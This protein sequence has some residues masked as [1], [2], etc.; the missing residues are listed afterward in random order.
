MHLKSR[1]FN[2]QK[3]K[4][5]KKRCSQK[6][7]FCAISVTGGT[8][9]QKVLSHFACVEGLSLLYVKVFKGE[10]TPSEIQLQTS[11]GCIS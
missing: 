2:S 9:M 7:R 8:A 11:F 1:L 10:Y 4:K 5:K 3:V 6:E